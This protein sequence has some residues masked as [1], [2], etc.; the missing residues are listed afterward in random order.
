MCLRSFSIGP[1]LMSGG[2]EYN[3]GLSDEQCCNAGL[4]V[5]CDCQSISGVH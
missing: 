5:I 1:F 3:A 2:S 4:V